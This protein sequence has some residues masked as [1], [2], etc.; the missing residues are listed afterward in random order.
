IGQAAE[1]DY[2]GT[3]CCKALKEEG[4][5]VVLVNSNPATI[6]TDFEFADRIYIEPLNVETVAK[7][8]QKEKPDAMIATMAGQT[9]LNLAM[10]LWDVIASNGIE[11]LGT[12]LNTIELAEDREKFAGLMHKINEPIPK[13]ERASNLEQAKS[14]LK[15]IGIPCIV[16]P[17][18]ALGGSGS[19]IVRNESEFL[20]FV[21]RALSLSG[22]GSCLI[23]QSVE[24][25]CEME[26]EVIRDGLD[27]CITICNMENLDSMGVHTGESIVVAPSQTLTDKEY[28]LLRAVAIKVVRALEVR[29]ACNIQFALNQKTG[30]YYIIEVNPRTSRSSALASKATGYPIARVATKIALGYA[31]HEIENKITGKS[32]AFEPALDYCVVKIPKWP[33]D[34]LYASRL[35]GTQM[36]STGEVMAI[37]RNFEEALQKAIH[38]LEMKQKVEFDFSKDGEVEKCLQP[39]ELRIFAIKDILRQKI[40]NV[41]EISKISKVNPWFIKKLSNIVEMENEIA[42]LSLSDPS[43]HS[44]FRTAKGMGFS[45]GQISHLASISTDSIEFI[46]EQNSIFPTFKMVDTCA[47]EFAAITPYYYST[48]GSEDE[49]QLISSKGKGKK[50]IILGSGPIRIGQGIEFDYATVHAVISLRELGFESIIVNSNPETVS[51]DF[52]VSSK[53][54]FEPLTFENVAGIV[55]K[56][57]EIEGVVVQFGGQT[58]INLSLPLEQN[59]INVLGTSVASIDASQNRKK[60]KSLM[61]RLKIPLVES[62]VAFSRE[63]AVE[64]ARNISYPLLIR[65]SYVLGGRAMEIVYDEPHLLLKI[66]EAI[67]VSGSHAI[68]MDRFLEDAL[69]VD[70]DALS[71]GKTVK[72]AGIMEQIE[73]AGIHSG[74]SSCVVP[75]IRIPNAALQKIRDYTKRIC[76]EL[77]I[78]GLANIQMAIKGSDVYVLEVNPR[79]SRTVPYLSKSMGIP[80]AKIAAALQVGKKLTD[81]FNDFDFELLPKKG[82]FSVKVPVFPFIKFADVDPV[83]SPEMKSTGEV[84][85]IAKSFEEAYLKAHIA[86][87]NTFGG[88][89]FLGSCGKWKKILNEAFAKAGIKVIDSEKT[90]VH[91]AISLIKSGKISFVA[92]GIRAQG[93]NLEQIRKTEDLRKFAIQRKLPVISSYFAAL[94]IAESLAKMK[95]KNGS[96]EPIALNDL[97]Q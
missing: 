72:I 79:A 13:S 27:N 80:I 86:A 9:G 1:F 11:L 3:Q 57:G 21:E 26:Y 34:K 64:I 53:L 44:I 18:F 36:K 50:V 4:V 69:E 90:S 33:F 52:D 67:F 63:E 31:L 61:Q 96:F 29:G 66:D 92:D 49:S 54:Y 19:G 74:D 6:Q 2:S 24:G 58:A 48:Y 68:I 95:G 8:I 87:G 41:D 25:M 77:H 35:L 15:N 78:I 62:G 73:E 97:I 46:R 37:G 89:V 17:D 16:R 91:G 23:E 70:V 88:T 51:T 76:L 39:N 94:R 40:L 81:Y 60:F 45:D 10:K 56:E 75:A 22:S 82:Y 42:S 59:G 32:A 30:E 7:I 84:M 12:S 83:L 55:A 14:A 85:G 65:P 38:S 43:T 28:H 20:P 5:V 93:N 47:S 71:D